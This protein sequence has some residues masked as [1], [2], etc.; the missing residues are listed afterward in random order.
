MNKNVLKILET[1][2]YIVKL[3]SNSLVV[4]NQFGRLFNKKS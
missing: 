4:Y 3:K 1:M 2:G